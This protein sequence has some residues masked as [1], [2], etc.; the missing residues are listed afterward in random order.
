MSRHNR[1][2]LA[3]LWAGIAILFAVL[4]VVLGKNLLQR[5]ATRGL[6]YRET[7]AKRITNDWHSFG[8]TWEITNTAIRDDSDERGSK[9]I[10]GSSQWSDYSIEGNIMLRGISGY[11]SDVGFLLRTSNE[12]EGVYAYNG[13]FA[14]LHRTKDGGAL[15]MIARVG[16]G[17]GTLAQSKFPSDLETHAW[18]HVK[19]LAVGCR[20]AASAQLIE[21]A[22][23]PI[24]I[25]ATDPD[26]FEHGHA[27][28][29]S[30]H[31]GGE[32]R[33]ILIQS[34]NMQS[35][36]A[37]RA[38][39]SMP[40]SQLQ[41]LPVSATTDSSNPSS[42]QQTP[43]MPISSALLKSLIVPQ[44][45]SITGQV[46]LTSPV[47][48]VQDPSGGIPLRLVT[49]TPLKIGDEVSATGDLSADGLSPVMN[50]AVVHVLW[51]GSPISALS[52]TASRLATGAYD[53]EYIEVEGV[54]LGQHFISPK[55][56]A[57]DFS[58]GSQIYEALLPYGRGT[59]LS[60]R[61]E[62]RSTVRLRGI[63]TR[64]PQFL[65]DNA[66]FGV[67]IRTAN[68]VQV[69]AGPPW[70][71][72]RNLLIL[73]C[74][75]ITI[76]V[77]IGLLYRRIERLKLLAVIKERERIAYEMHDTLAQ[78]VAGIGFQLEAIRATVPA[79]QPILHRQLALAHELV[80]HSHAEARTSIDMLRPQQLQQ[81]GLLAGLKDCAQT[82]IS[83]SGCMISTE[84]LGTPVPITIGT[85]DALFRIGREAIAN[86]I[87][88][89]SPTH[90]HLKL[91]FQ[92]KRVFL[93]IQDNGVG[94]N[95]NAIGHTLGLMSMRKRAEAISAEL[96]ITSHL[97]KG[98]IVAINAPVD[99]DSFLTVWREVF[100]WK[101]TE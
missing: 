16:Q 93:L 47:V 65:S 97:G 32:W 98:T 78:S 13:Y 38:L 34:A 80:R 14:I 8:G 85:A 64:D 84:T 92:G 69:I 30:S 11:A 54:A 29:T 96:T 95:C 21:T 75:L 36:A 82:L 24:V 27:G 25:E 51:E 42:A 39:P 101:R 1:G 10:T 67:L 86:A 90:L 17:P 55:I 44:K 3:V 49:E 53:G 28:L 62:P 88:H 52:V 41:S 35:L 58:A 77:G 5:E 19:F 87:R 72:L 6:P 57:L 18:Y 48:V 81:Y 15:F 61:I 23:K 31:A 70:W 46:T 74:L 9:L 63:A 4:I 33:D 73:A 7:V 94:F 56:L 26:C 83:N 37:M 22:S 59:D 79:D 66:A 45:A 20:L 91:E 76:V 99:Q 71:R 2:A 40:Q 60:H 43:M 50:N 100:R 12:E 89:A 68:D